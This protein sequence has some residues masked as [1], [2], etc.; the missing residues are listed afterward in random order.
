MKLCLETRSD[1]QWNLIYKK[2]YEFTVIFGLCNIILIKLI[3]IS[4]DNE[5]ST[6]AH[7]SFKG[8]KK[9]R[10]NFK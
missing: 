10:D 6:L 4:K 1:K 8:D 3:K 9:F 7:I 2:K 5:E